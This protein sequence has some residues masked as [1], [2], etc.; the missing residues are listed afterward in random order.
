MVTR[1]GNGKWEPMTGK[2]ANHPACI[3]AEIID[4]ANDLIA[5]LDPRGK[6]QVWNRAAETLTGYPRNEVMGRSDVWKRLYPDAEYR[7]SITKRIT[8]IITSLRFFE[9]LET[10]ITTKTGEQRIILWN[11]RQIESE[12]NYWAIAIGRDITER[13]R[14]EEALQ[15]SEQK[16]HD[17]IDNANDLIQSITPEGKIIYVNQAWMKTLGYS[18]TDIPHLSLN[19][20]IHPDSLLHCM[21]A[22]K[23]L[24]SGENIGT[25]EAVFIS[26]DGKKISVEGNVNCRFINGK[27]AY[28]RG[29]FRDVTERKRAELDLVSAQQRLKEAHRLAHIGTWDWI[30]ENDTVFWSEELYNIAGL[31]SSLPAPTYA[32]HPRIYAPSSW[33]R[34]SGA[35]T[36]ALATGEPYN[37]ELELIRPDGSKRWVNAFGGVKRGSDGKISGFHGTVQD[38]TERKLAEEAL[39]TSEERFRSIFDM[40]NDGIHIHNILPDGKPGRFIEVNEV[41]CRMLQ[42]TREEMLKCGPLDIITGY[43]SR[44]FDEI[45]RELSTTGRSFFEAEH[46]RKDG[47]IVPVEINTHVVTLQGK[48]VMV[49]VVRDITER[50][51]AETAVHESEQKFHIIVDAARDG[52]LVAD[53]ETRR[54]VMANAAILKQTGY[55][56]TEL[57]SLS[58]ADI[59]RPADLPYAIEEFEKQIRGEITLSSNIPILRKDGTVFFVEISSA[60]IILQG[61]KCLLGIFRDI[62]ER[63]QM[64]DVISKSLKEKEMLLK[65]IHHRVK[66]N[67]QVISSLLYMQAKTLKDETV[68]GILRESQNRVKSIALV[69]EK[70]YQSTD[71][72]RIDYSEYLREITGHL[73]ESYQVDPNIISLQLNLEN[74]FLHINKAVPC[75][76]ILNEMISNSLKH[77]FPNR[78]KG[79]ITIDMR[80]K[81]DRY[82]VI[83]S[84]DGIGIPEGITFERT[85]SLGMQ[86]IY[87]LVEQIS[88]SIELEREGGTRYTITFPV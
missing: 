40:V 31:D 78:R 70:L 57:L 51:Q 43:H 49:S 9:N 69:H 11:I 36:T 38:I 19:D 81:A 20:I 79:L 7:R 33:D 46:L 37:L 66:N 48:R 77:A 88:G 61:R 42:Y 45:M 28:T 29:I 58:V 54:L 32:E 13:K 24:L 71:L 85:E 83:Y 14:A 84:D 34:L 75:S 68:K 22:F 4:N 10:K 23:R 50:R 39:R 5:V 72:D 6:V 74:V 73:F 65:E 87:G 21:V 16:Y 64:A 12:G 18:E 30:I 41:A 52:L 3:E 53:Q 26:K 56:E 67:M 44:P 62:T 82:I 1:T 35:V 2:N 59:I 55:S 8:D 60:P 76:L 27:P 17:I 86:L 25:I 63:K 47:I 80:M 15:E